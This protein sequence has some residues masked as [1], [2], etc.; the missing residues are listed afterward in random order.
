MEDDLRQ[1][2]SFA[3]PTYADYALAIAPQLATAYPRLGDTGPELILE[4]G[5]ALVADV[6]RF[7]ARIV[8]VK[9]IRSRTFA[10]ASGSIHNI[11]PTLHNKQMPMRVFRSGTGTSSRSGGRIDVVGYTCMEHDRLYADYDGPVGVGD[12]VVFGNVGAYSIVMMPPFI[13]PSPG[14]VAY[15]STCDTSDMA[16]HAESVADVFATYV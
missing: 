4:P 7:A 15:E 11:K 9:T 13:R 10:L 12:W 8:D 16:K 14:I 6:M 3:I 2:F 1:Q 5:T